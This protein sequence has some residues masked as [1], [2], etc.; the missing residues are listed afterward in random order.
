MREGL[1]LGRPQ[2]TA[3]PR[4][5]WDCSWRLTK[6]QRGRG[7]VATAGGL[8]EAL[9]AWWPPL[10]LARAFVLARVNHRPGRRAQGV[11]TRV[12]VVSGS[13][14]GKRVCVCVWGV[15]KY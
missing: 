2:V 13:A 12:Y 4:V 11:S 1:G 5:P 14:G 6:G 8:E 7:P 3:S 9:A 10:G 15:C